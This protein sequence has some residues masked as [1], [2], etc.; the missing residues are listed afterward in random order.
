LPGITSFTSYT[1]EVYGITFGYPDGWTVYAA[2]SQKW[3]P[4]TWSDRYAD[5]FVNPA[6]RDG[7]D[8]AFLVWQQPAG[9]GAD[10]TTHAGL[11][12]WQQAN[13]CDAEVEPCEP[14][15]DAA[16]PMCFGRADCRPAVIVPSSDGTQ[17]VFADPGTGL[18]TIVSLGRPDGFPAAARYGGG[19]QLLKSILTTLDVWTPEA[20]QVPG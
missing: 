5:L 15:P 1:S 17:A 6:S 10:V 12:A 13:L 3:Q 19:I 4:G 20:G 18:V 14:A 8:I 9:S 7:E 16:V 2:A 11:T